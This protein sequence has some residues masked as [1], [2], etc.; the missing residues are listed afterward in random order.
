MKAVFENIRD[1]VIEKFSAANKSIYIAV[2]WFTDNEI[3]QILYSKVNEGVKIIILTNDDEI[4][5]KST[6]FFCELQNSGVDIR[7]LENN[8]ILMHNKFFIIDDNIV[9]T[10]SYNLTNKANYNSENILIVEDQD[11]VTEYLNHF[12]YI[13]DKTVAFKSN[14]SFVF[15]KKLDNSNIIIKEEEEYDSQDK[16]HLANVIF[17][18]LKI[19]RL[20]IGALEKQLGTIKGINVIY[21]IKYRALDILER[22]LRLLNDCPSER[23]KLNDL[24]NTFNSNF[25]YLDESNDL[26]LNKSEDIYINQSKLSIYFACRNIINDPEKLFS[27]IEMLSLFINFKSEI[28]RKLLI[29]CYFEY[30]YLLLIEQYDLKP[31]VNNKKGCM[32]TLL[33]MGAILF[34]IFALI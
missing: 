4:N 32:L 29:D 20:N 7:K 30:L 33:F 14:E 25:I 10:G 15:E 22:K 26:P 31:I 18:D 12:W 6:Y 21:L 3:A 16:V 19:I 8:G 24:M 2:A 28:Q 5:K 34:L 17:S 23:K 27:Q 9:I 11:V 1:V 13:S